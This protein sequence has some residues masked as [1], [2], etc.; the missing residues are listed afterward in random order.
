MV[1]QKNTVLAEL[2]GKKVRLTYCLFV[3][4]VH[5]DG[6]W[7]DGLT[8]YG[9]R[10]GL[11]WPDRP[12]EEDEEP[13]VTCDKGRMLALCLNAWLR[14]GLR[15]WGFGTLWMIFLHADERFAI[16]KENI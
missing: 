11:E 2:E 4:P 7:Q 6:A 15:Q 16:I 9:V 10:A 14:G 5:A 3:Q 8:A 1:V 12:S 13:G